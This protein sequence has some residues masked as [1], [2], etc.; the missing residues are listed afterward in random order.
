MRCVA[1]V[2]DFPHAKS[3]HGLAHLAACGG[4]SDLLAIG[5]PHIELRLDGRMARWKARRVPVPDTATICEW[6]GIEYVVM[7][8]D[9]PG[10]VRR[11]TEFRPD[12]GVI[13]G[14]RVLTDAVLTTAGCPILNVHPGV[15]PRNRG[16]DAVPWAVHHGW[17]QGATVHRVTSCL[18]GGPIYAISVLESVEPD[19]SF[20]EI[21]ARIDA[22]QLSLVLH[23]LRAVSRA[24]RPAEVQTSPGSYH[25]RY[26]SPESELFRRLGAYCADYDSALA[27]WMSEEADL[28]RRLGP[29]FGLVVG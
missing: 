3:W 12:V 11:L 2:Y 9:D 23:T 20:V 29:R 17:P 19:D 26:G 7:P 6:A 10:C 21:T 25:S 28:V 27:R 13:F 16:L 18:D 24:D 1:F 15:L 4:F 8:H 5:A 22:L 14:A